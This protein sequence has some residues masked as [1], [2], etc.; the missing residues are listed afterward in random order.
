MG[1][2][3]RKE[4]RLKAW[5]EGDVCLFQNKQPQISVS[6]PKDVLVVVH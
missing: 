3:G 2:L 4:T 1:S 6:S 5:G